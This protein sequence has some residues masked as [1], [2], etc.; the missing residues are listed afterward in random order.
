MRKAVD[1]PIHVVR[2][3]YWVAGLGFATGFL[4]YLSLHPVF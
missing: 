1:H 2:P 3:F 4:G